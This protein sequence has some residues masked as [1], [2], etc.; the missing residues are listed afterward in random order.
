VD[1]RGS[2]NAEALRSR[3]RAQGEAATQAARY[4]N[5]VVPVAVRSKRERGSADVG[6]GRDAMSGTFK[7]GEI[8]NRKNAARTPFLM[9]P[10]SARTYAR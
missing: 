3:A 8:T 7:F 1:L 2:G 4:R 5:A 6:V 9:T 10:S